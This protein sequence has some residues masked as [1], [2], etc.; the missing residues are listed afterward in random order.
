M[1]HR[2]YQ[3]PSVRFKPILRIDPA[4]SRAAQFAR[5]GPALIVKFP[6]IDFD[7]LPEW[8]PLPDDENEDEDSED[9]NTEAESCEENSNVGKRPSNAAMQSPPNRSQS[10]A[11]T[12]MSSVARESTPKPT[13][14]FQ[15][16][17]VPA[18]RTASVPAWGLPRTYVPSNPLQNH[19]SRVE[20]PACPNRSTPALTSPTPDRPDRVVEGDPPRTESPVP[21]TGTRASRLGSPL[22]NLLHLNSN[23]TRI[24]ESPTTS[25]SPQNDSAND[26]SQIRNH[27][28]I[29]EISTVPLMPNVPSPSPMPR[30]SQNPSLTEINVARRSQQ[31]A[32]GSA[33]TEEQST[34]SLAMALSKPWELEMHIPY[35]H[36]VFSCG[37]QGFRLFPGPQ[38]VAH[39]AEPN[40]S[41]G[42]I[43]NTRQ[44]P[45]MSHPQR[46]RSAAINLGVNT[47]HS[48]ND[49]TQSRPAT[50]AAS[51]DHHISATPI[52]GAVNNTANTN[53]EHN[54]AHVGP[55]IAPSDP[56]IKIEN[57]G[58][59]ALRTSPLFRQQQKTQPQTNA[60]PFRLEMQANADVNQRGHHEV[61]TRYSEADRDAQNFLARQRLAQ[62]RR[63]KENQSSR[64]GGDAP[65]QSNV[66]KAT[67]PMFKMSAASPVA[68]KRRANT[69]QPSTSRIRMPS[70]LG[71]PTPAP[72][73]RSN[74][75]NMY[76][77]YGD[78]ENQVLQGFAA[79]RADSVARSKQEKRPR[80][81]ND[82][83]EETVRP[84]RQAMQ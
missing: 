29:R 14:G 76:S 49:G 83:D 37:N 71:D 43:A 61:Q 21:V 42:N 81:E 58:S 17:F 51:S 44:A 68:N 77:A 18:R 26:G 67:I 8:P 2:R 38:P 7:N 39:G 78:V 64:V 47:H 80:T 63:Q 34:F 84:K 62:I 53:R 75:H 45:P 74:L 69:S 31:I 3:G 19:L 6:P 65:R 20:T 10:R 48:S 66:N 57:S 59:N 40:K 70:Y 9:E 52:G 25:I 1:A 82:E 11:T 12:R 79:Y 72:T 54:R 33:S 30:R 5:R 56:K 46:H 55:E 50:E 36:I 35:Y 4:E 16:R 27:A 13:N 24:S 60:Q 15:D 32:E 41:E 28:P 73:S 22:S 23:L